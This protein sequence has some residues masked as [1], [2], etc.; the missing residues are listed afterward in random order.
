MTLTFLSK[1]KKST[2]DFTLHTTFQKTNLK[3]LL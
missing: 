2:F 1:N 3:K